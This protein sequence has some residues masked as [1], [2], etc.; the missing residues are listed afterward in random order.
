MS[1]ILIK[2]PNCHGENLID[3]S[4]NICHCKFCRKDF[5]IGPTENGL[6]DNAVKLRN[7]LEFDEAYTELENILTNGNQSAELYY[8]FLLCDYGVSYVDID[9]ENKIRSYPTLN[10]LDRKSIFD[11]DEYKKLEKILS[12]NE[13]QLKIYKERLEEIDKLRADSIKLMEKQEPFDIFICYKRTKKIE[14]EDYLTKDSE[15]ARRLY[16]KFTKWGLKVFFA[17]ETLHHEFAGKAF[18]PII[19]SALMSSKIFILVCS[20]PKEPEIL[21]SIWVKN[22]WQ[23]FKKRVEIEGDDKIRFVPVFDNG[24][25]P[26]Q[27]PRQIQ[28]AG[29]QGVV[30]NDE[31]DK[32]IANVINSVVK[33]KG[34]KRIDEILIKTDN[35]NIN[36]ATTNITLNA[37]KGY[38]LQNLDVSQ[39]A[40]YRMA[41]SDMKADNKRSYG[42]AYKSLNEITKNNSHNFNANLAKIKCDFETPFDSSIDDYS[43]YR[44]LGSKNYDKFLNDFI[45]LISINDNN[46][47]STQ[48]TF[49][50][51]FKN[52]ID[53]TFK[54]S[55]FSTFSKIISENPNENPYL[56]LFS[57][58]K[59]SKKETKQKAD[60]LKRVFLNSIFNYN[61]KNIN[62]KEYETFINDSINR[63]FVPIYASF[64]EDGS[65][66]LINLYYTTQKYLL[67]KYKLNKF[68]TRLIDNLIER[69]L[70]IH[71]YY[72]MALLIKFFRINHFN[73]SYQKDIY[74]D[75]ETDQQDEETKDLGKNISLYCG[76]DYVSIIKHFNKIDIEDENIKED[77]SNL[78]FIL[79]KILK[80]GYVW[81]ED[82]FGPFSFAYEQIIDYI[83][84][85]PEKNEKRKIPKIAFEAAK[86]F[87]ELLP[88]SKI[89][90]TTY[91]NKLIEIGDTF[92]IN[93]YF[94]EGE[95]FYQ[96][97]LTYNEDSLDILW[98]LVKCEM[99]CKTNFE[100]FIVKKN[101]HDCISFKNLIEK[102]ISKYPEKVNVHENF[103]SC[104][105]NT[106]NGRQKDKK[107][108]KKLFGYLS[109]MDIASNKVTPVGEIV[110]NFN[111][112]NY[113]SMSKAL[114]FD[115]NQDKYGTHIFFIP[116]IFSIIFSLI[117]FVLGLFRSDIPYWMIPIIGLSFIVLMIIFFNKKA[118]FG[119]HQTLVSIDGYNTVYKKGRLAA[120]VY[121]FIIILFFFVL[122]GGLLFF[123]TNFYPFYFLSYLDDI[124][125]FKIIFSI[126]FALLTISFLTFGNLKGAKI[127]KVSSASLG[128]SLILYF[129][130]ICAIL[131]L[132]DVFLNIDPIYPVPYISPFVFSS[133]GVIVAVTYIRLFFNKIL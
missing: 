30:L 95:V 82:E 74:M 92:T 39:E 40:L 65:Y 105:E 79:G 69:I 96:E 109:N 130:S 24:F 77:Y 21:S 62:F 5:Y 4:M 1:E 41:L 43:L 113:Y 120:S 32:S 25:Q 132:G 59:S 81:K 36:V 26:E 8:Q 94:E 91:M 54:I 133:L 119:R 20:S 47:E 70:E 53:Y 116:F 2:C 118:L 99:K 80:G 100:M 83:N 10:R 9:D 129:T 6:F 93:N 33:K 128:A 60:A 56:I 114:Y 103:Y 17:E 35:I 49:F 98:K 48:E 44:V 117:L 50:K 125:V 76:E 38:Q 122:F 75:D 88:S 58:L 14:G 18:E 37:F 90:N 34:Q 61:E 78:Y 29:F 85:K 84:Q 27:L 71:P 22:E 46:Q 57:T 7:R 51:I 115:S 23:R 121:K 55:S 15:T 110:D 111:N 12:N 102:Y 16:D 31:F 73:Y 89:K 72:D 3:S 45:D 67:Y 106:K 124:K 123:Q 104:V 86:A 68:L 112:G 127:N 19:Y 13:E 131:V 66:E 11:K 101:M 87:F 97:A 42:K 63:I 107:G 28:K 52:T 64:G 108:Y 126:L